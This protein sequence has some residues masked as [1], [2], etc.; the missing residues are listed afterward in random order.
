MD[1]R[2]DALTAFLNARL[3]REGSHG[4]HLTIGVLLL[5]GATSIF[6]LI[7]VE[8]G[9]GGPLTLLDARFSAWLRTYHQPAAI[10]AMIII[11]DL[12]STVAV[13]VLT[14]ALA[15][16]LFRLRHRC[17]LITVVLTV[18]G[19][20]F[21]NIVLKN[22]FLRARPQ[23]D[24][25]ILTLSSHSFPSG[26]AMAATCFYGVVAAFAFWKMREWPWRV[27]AITLAVFLV[28]LV[29][30]SRIY[31]GAHYLS[32]VLAAILEG[33]AW[34]TFCLTAAHTICRVRHRE[35]PSS[36]VL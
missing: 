3:S 19:G 21:L 24:D 5:I 6:A 25:P 17:W 35:R 33:S 30:F 10:R 20:M 2:F 36:A 15:L 9:E 29:G 12:H 1:R 23:F 32:D 16:Y 14:L 27:L 26:H 34:L 4:L 7:A 22:I 28:L 13:S 18:F 11:S 31:L 8:L